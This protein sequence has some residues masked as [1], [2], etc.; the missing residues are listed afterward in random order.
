MADMLGDLGAEA[1]ADADVS[2]EASSRP[3]ALALG[4]VS[5]AGKLDSS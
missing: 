5:A 4:G 1:E 3:V 2:L